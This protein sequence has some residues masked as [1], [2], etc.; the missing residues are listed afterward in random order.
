M[1]LKKETGEAIYN[2]EAKG[3]MCNQIAYFNIPE[4]ERETEVKELDAILEKIFT[5]AEKIKKTKKL[6]DQVFLH[7]LATMDESTGY[8]LKLNEE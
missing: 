6:N 4:D 2:A 1:E 5:F 8:K 3:P 7:S